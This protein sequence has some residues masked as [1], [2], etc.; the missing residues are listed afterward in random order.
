MH[1]NDISYKCI[2]AAIEIQNIIEPS[3][4]IPIVDAKMGI[5]TRQNIFCYEFDGPRDNGS[6]VVTTFK[7]D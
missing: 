1:K 7:T 4:C 2:G 3:E 5:S 6:V